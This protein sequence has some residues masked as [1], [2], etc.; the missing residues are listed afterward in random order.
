MFDSMSQA[1]RPING[2]LAYFN[3]FFSNSWIMLLV[4]SGFNNSTFCLVYHDI[5]FS[6][7]YTT[8]LVLALV[9]LPFLPHVQAGLVCI[10]LFCR[11]WNTPQF[12]PKF[13]QS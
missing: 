3:F 11:S 7:A 4:C 2:Q 6:Q 8:E 12:L 10:F 13:A 5:F 9:F 1:V